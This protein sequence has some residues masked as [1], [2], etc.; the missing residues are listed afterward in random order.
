MRSSKD[1][2]A[3]PLHTSFP[4]NNSVSLRSVH[5]QRQ[6]RTSATQPGGL[7]VTLYPGVFSVEP[8][9]TRL[10]KAPSPVC[11]LPPLPTAPQR[12]PVGSPYQSSSE[13]NH[14]LHSS[15][16]GGNKG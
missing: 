10:S 9:E 16:F 15:S 14:Q 11:P 7:T 13:H 5:Q 12:D 2:K 3:P 1:A 6:G 4:Q 8:Q